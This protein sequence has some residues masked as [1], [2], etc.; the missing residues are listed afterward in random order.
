MIRTVVLAV[1]I[2]F[3]VSGVAAA[4]GPPDACGPKGDLGADL[5]NNVAA[6]SRCFEVRMYTAQPQ[7]DDGS[8][9]IDELHQRFRDGEVAI[10]EKHGAEV[11]AVWQRLDNPNTLVW[12][13]AY[14]DR[15]HRDEVWAAFREDPD[16]DELIG[17]YPAP[18]EGIEVFWMSA[19]DFSA[20]K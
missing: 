19:S 12:M 9:G 7:A 13:L 6:D 15:A 2:G 1:V 8:G 11:V 5:S 14:R 16:W 4:Q 10:F 18:L 17:K 20:L 3:G